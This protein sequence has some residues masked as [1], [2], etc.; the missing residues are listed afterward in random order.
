MG[1][2]YIYKIVNLVNNKIYIGKTI[3]SVEHRLKEHIRTSKRKRT[4]TSYLYNAMNAYGEENFD[5]EVIEECQLS[6]IDERERFWIKKLNSQNPNIGYNIQEGG[7][8]GAV[9]S[10]EFKITD[11]QLAGLSTAWHLPASDKLK[12]KLSEIRTGCDVSIETRQ[13]LREKSLGRKRIHK[14]TVNKNIKVELLD[15]YLNNG[16]ELGY[17][18][19]YYKKKD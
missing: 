12:K 17:Y 11:N 3:N 5:I 2:G 14:G 8:G 9:R 16:W 1:I 15:D 7:E 18:K 6:I 13:K 10:K 4:Y 19:G